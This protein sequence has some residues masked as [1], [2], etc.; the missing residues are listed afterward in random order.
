M[1][2]NRVIYLIL[3][4]ITII[5]GLLS[6]KV[7]GLPEIASA[8]SGD[9]LWAMMVFFIIAFIFNN[10]STIFIISWAIIFSYSIE[11]SQLYHAPWIETI[12]NTTLGALVLGF[13]FLWSDLVC[14]TVGVIT[15]AIIDRLINY[16]KI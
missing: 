12:R 13:G 15:G 9:V 3:I 5:L 8:Y 4:V 14:Y 10:K 11:I 7:S 2:R 16:K 1:K 6:R